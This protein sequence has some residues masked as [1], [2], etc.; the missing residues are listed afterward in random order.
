MTN[1]FALVQT[2]LVKNPLSGS[3]CEQ[4]D[5]LVRSPTPPYI[6]CILIVMLNHLIKGQ[7]RTGF[8]LDAEVEFEST[9]SNL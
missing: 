1:L 4:L 2:L 3:Q 8:G 6:L 5:L 9:I 7:D